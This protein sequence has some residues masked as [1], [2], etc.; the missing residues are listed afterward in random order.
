MLLL[1]K[2][3]L[4]LQ[5]LVANLHMTIKSSRLRKGI[6]ATIGVLFF[7]T[8]L[9]L[10]AFYSAAEILPEEYL[11]RGDGLYLVFIL[12]YY[13]PLR[14]L[15]DQPIRNTVTIMATAWVYTMFIYIISHRIAFQLN[16]DN[17]Q[18]YS[19]ILQTLLYL[20]TYKLYF[21]FMNEKFIYTI[22]NMDRVSINILMTLSISTVSLLFLMNYSYVYGHSLFS[23][24]FEP[25]LLIIVST[26]SLQLASSFVKSSK[27]AESIGK[28]IRKDPLTRLGNREAMMEDVNKRITRDEIFGLIFADLDQFKHVNDTY[29]HQAGDDYLVA[30][31]NTARTFLGHGDRFYRISGDEFVVVCEYKNCYSLMKKFN[32]FKFLNKPRGIDFLGLSTGHAIY[33]KEERD[34]VDLLSKA[35]ERMYQEK[36]RKHKKQ[37]N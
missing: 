12:I 25:M 8:L 31:A 36:K 16:S 10:V 28:R 7:V 26:L 3:L 24:M 15:T 30:F 6:W 5:M 33:P 21:R 23:E 2:V 14:F 17:L 32:D 9:F 27:D 35:D 1:V 37:T 19:L 4:V 22:R 34:L 13:I 11:F 20:V 18:L 29:G